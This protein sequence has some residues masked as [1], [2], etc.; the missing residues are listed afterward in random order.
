MSQ[1]DYARLLDLAE[2]L[3]WD[4]SLSVSSDRKVM[5]AIDSLSPEE[6]LSDGLVRALTEVQAL[7]G[8]YTKTIDTLLG[9]A[10]TLGKQSETLETITNL[11][12]VGD[13]A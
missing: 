3:G 11:L 13:D 2:D 12:P 8:A 5:I 6:E 7:Q 4:V 9:L 1:S 10:N